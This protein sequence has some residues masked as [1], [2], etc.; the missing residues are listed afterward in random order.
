VSPLSNDPSEDTRTEFA[1]RVVWED[2][3]V[4]EFPR[5]A[6]E[7]A[8]AFRDQINHSGGLTPPDYTKRRKGKATLLTRTFVPPPWEEVE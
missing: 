6:I 8:R 2:G 3:E 4:E 7:Y 1:V 5:N